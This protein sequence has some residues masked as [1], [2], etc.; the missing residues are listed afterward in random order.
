MSDEK[1]DKIEVNLEFICLNI[2]YKITFA[3]RVVSIKSLFLQFNC[4]NLKSIDY[5]LEYRLSFTEY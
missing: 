2:Q 5:Y 4:F 3:E 1:F